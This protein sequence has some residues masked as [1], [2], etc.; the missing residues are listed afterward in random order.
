MSEKPFISGIPADYLDL[1][2]ELERREAKSVSKPRVSDILGQG[3]LNL[4][5]V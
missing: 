3:R 4:D 2:Q 5:V 1:L